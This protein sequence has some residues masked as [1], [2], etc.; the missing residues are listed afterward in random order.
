MAFGDREVTLDNGVRGEP[1]TVPTANPTGFHQAISEPA[2][3]ESAQIRGCV[4]TPPDPGP[5]PVVIVVPGSLGVAPSHVFKA[6]LLTSA[7]IAACVIDPFGG[8]GVTSTVANQAQYSFAASA[9]DVLATATLLRDRDDI[10]ASRIGAQ[11][12]S[13]GGSAVLSAACMA[14]LIDTHGVSLRGVYAAYPWCGQQF[15]RPL[16]GDTVVRSVIG[17]QDEWCLPQQVQAYMHAMRL[18]GCNA[19]FR[20]FPGAHHSFDRDTPLELVEDA[21]IAPGAPTIYLRDDGAPIHPATG[22]ADPALSE[23]EAMIYGMKAGYGRRGAH[24][25]TE[26]DHA[27]RFHEDMMAFWNGTLAAVHPE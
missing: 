27:R 8:R 3:M 20:L 12:H 4:F 26:G 1:V 7:G 23:R 21:V 11:G 22:I 16:V 18:S 2:Q 10:D 24:I 14:G 19:S 6:E 25:G 17:D 5:W 15:E 13:R 9:W